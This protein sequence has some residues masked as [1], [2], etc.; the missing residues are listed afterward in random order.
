[1]DADKRFGGKVVQLR[2]LIDNA[3][4]LRRTDRERLTEAM[5]RISRR[6]PQVFVAIYTGTPGEL[7]DLR[8][9]GFWLLNRGVF[10]DVPADKSNAAGILITIDPRSKAAG[11]TFGYLLDPFLD[12]SNTFEC[13]LRGHPYWLEQRYTDGL[14][15]TLAH[16]ETIL[17]KRSRHALRHPR[18]FQRK[19][20]PSAAQAQ[21]AL[22]PVGQSRHL[23]E[24][25]KTTGGSP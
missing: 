6:L 9:F 20:Q 10:M 4:I 19:W 5:E 15:R 3:G 8:Q 22:A 17:C 12:E 21:P 23:P 13:L 2:K 16:L 25:K 11:I 1:M 7:S 24:K 18:A 14:V